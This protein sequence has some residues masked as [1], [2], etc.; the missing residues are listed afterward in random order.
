MTLFIW[1]LELVL[2]LLW[3][4]INDMRPRDGGLS[5][6]EIQRRLASPKTKRDDIKTLRIYSDS[7]SIALLLSI[8]STVVAML[9]TYVG[10]VRFGVVFAL[11]AV[12]LIVITPRLTHRLVG[13]LSRALYASCEPYLVRLVGKSRRMLSWLNNTSS[14]ND[15]AI[16]SKEELINLIEHGTTTILSPTERQRLAAGLEFSDKKISDI[17]TPR[18]AIVSVARNE[19]LGLL[20]L[21]ELYKKGFSRMPVIDK[22][23]DHVVGILYV[24][25]L[26]TIEGDKRHARTAE[27]A[28][29]A[30]VYFI[31]ETSSLDKAL[32]AFVKTNHHML[33][34]INEFRETVGLITLEDVLEALI[35]HAIQDEFDTSDSMRQTAEDNPRHNNKSLNGHDVA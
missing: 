8:V 17:M 12:V 4:I 33:I 32:A 35:G 3:I 20:T 11:L 22:D 13:R 27:S 25:Q 29:E 5:A 2:L 6:F 16:S 1:L 18:S 19:V 14:S 34:V 30:Q 15:I 10:I 23:I 26:L 21:D 28:M 9:F 24:Q 7:Q 31:S